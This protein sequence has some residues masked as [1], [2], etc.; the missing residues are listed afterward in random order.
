[1]TKYALAA[2]AVSAALFASP[3]SAKPSELKNL[4]A[5]A[6]PAGCADYRF[7]LFNLYRA[8]IWSDSKSLPGKQY[9]LSLTYR[10][11]FSRDELVETSIEEMSRISGRSEKSFSTAR[12]QL[13]SA[14]RSVKKGDRITAFRESPKRVRFFKNGR[15]T[16]SVT[17]NADLFMS[18]WLGPKT[19]FKGDRDEMLSGRCEA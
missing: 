14:F 17:S 9:G 4:V 18:I 2:L 8:E 5:S 10:S 6:K 13:R 7:L 19:R 15:A 12:K 16:G 3:A 11:D 1:M